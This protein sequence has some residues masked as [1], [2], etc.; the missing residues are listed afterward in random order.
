MNMNKM[1]KNEYV[2]PEIEILEVINEGTLCQSGYAEDSND[3][4]L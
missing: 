4:E 2:S 1:D 3:S